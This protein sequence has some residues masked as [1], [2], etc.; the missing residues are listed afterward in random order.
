MSST[1][2][3]TEIAESESLKPATSKEAKTLAEK[4]AQ[5]RALSY[6][7]CMSLEIK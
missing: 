1:K 3:K 2:E 5:H 7:R 4:I 6:P